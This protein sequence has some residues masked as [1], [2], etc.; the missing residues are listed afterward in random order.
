M[1]A[2]RVSRLLCLTPLLLLGACATSS[3][4]RLD[5]LVATQQK[6]DQAYAAGDMQAALKDYQALTKAVP[7]QAPYW[8]R[9]GNVRFRLG[10]PD[11]AVEAYRQALKLDPGNDEAWYNLGIVRLRMA[12][13]A[14]VQAAQQKAEGEAGTALQQRSAGLA[15]GIARLTGG[16]HAD[17]EKAD[18]VSA[19]ASPPDATPPPDARANGTGGGGT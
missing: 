18:A 2:R 3:R 15:D 14:F 19:P 11:E 9:L 4:H 1:N 10:Q 12:E 6:A 8:F 7:R 13:A 16:D 5:T 17:K